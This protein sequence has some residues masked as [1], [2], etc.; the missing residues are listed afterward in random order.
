MKADAQRAA[1]VQFALPIH[2]PCSNPKETMVSA[3]LWARAWAQALEKDS[4]WATRTLMATAVSYYAI[5][6]GSESELPSLGTA[7]G[8]LRDI[9]SME[10]LR[11]GRS[12]RGRARSE[13]KK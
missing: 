7:S 13:P 5:A 11:E 10:W 2:D 8:R 1:G 3:K 9:R 12:A 6:V 4:I